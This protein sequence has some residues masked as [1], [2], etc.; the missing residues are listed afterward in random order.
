VS[1]GQGSSA[2]ITNN[3]RTC[4]SLSRAERRTCPFPSST[5]GSGSYSISTC[6][7][8]RR[9]A[10]RI[11][12]SPSVAPSPVTYPTLYQH[13]VGVPFPPLRSLASL[14]CVS[15]SLSSHRHRCAHLTGSTFPTRPSFRCVFFQMSLF[16]PRILTSIFSLTGL[17][18]YLRS[19]QHHAAPPVLRLLCIACILHRSM[20][21]W[22]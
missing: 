14:A 5:V 3:L 10:P 13:S 4:Q 1:S 8:A 11:A 2:R 16:L 21:G 18:F 7:Q 17:R 20:P 19:R 15:A 22:V 6:E 12:Q 9:P